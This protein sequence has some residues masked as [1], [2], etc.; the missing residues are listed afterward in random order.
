MLSSQSDI[1]LSLSTS[2]MSGRNGV[3]LA[4]GYL[5]T[6]VRLHLTRYAKSNERRS[7]P[8]R[9]NPISVRIKLQNPD[10][11]QTTDGAKLT[12]PIV[13]RWMYMA[14]NK[15]TQHQKC[16]NKGE[17]KD[18]AMPTMDKAKAWWGRG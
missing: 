4:Q 5:G 17:R 11:S 13:F 14:L 2:Y 15:D 7:V 9:T 16:E 6:L 10:S 18:S 8:I 3:K 12:L 1:D